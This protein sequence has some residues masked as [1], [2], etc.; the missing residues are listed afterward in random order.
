[1]E[2]A[3][4]LITDY[5]LSGLAHAVRRRLNARP[6]VQSRR[7]A[8]LVRRSMAESVLAAQRNYQF[9]KDILI[10]ILMPVYNTDIDMLGCV[11]ESVIAQTYGR[12]ELCICDA[13]DEAHSAVADRCEKYAVADS[14]IKYRRLTANGGIAANTNECA[15]AASGEYFALL[16]H[17]DILH[18][19][20]LYKVAREIEQSGADFIYT[21]ELTFAGSIDNVLLTN[22]KPDYSPDTLCGNNYICHFTAFARELY[23][24]VCGF[25]SEYNGSQDHDIFLRMTRAANK[26]AHIPEILYFWRAH[27][28]SVVE[29]VS[30]K[31]YAVDAGK[32]AV[33]DN[34]ADWGYQAEVL[35]TD[36]YPTVYRIKY[37]ISNMP[38]VSVII[39]TG[40]NAPAKECKASLAVTGYGNYEVI[41][42]AADSASIN[43]CVRSVAKGDYIL[44]LDGRAKPGKADWMEELLRYAMRQEVGAVGTGL[45]NKNGT[46]DCYYMITGI[47]KDGIVLPTGRGLSEGDNGYLGRMGFV[48]NVNVPCPACLMVSRDKYIAAGGLDEKLSVNYN[49]IDLCLKLRQSGYNNVYTPF[50]ALRR[51]ADG[52]AKKSD[53]S[54]GAYGARAGK[55]EARYLAAKWGDALRDPY[56]NANFRKDGTYLL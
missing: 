22:L 14:R 4:S 42:T 7:A 28:G 44:L 8:G 2:S 50:A 37:N 31:S 25:R 52:S 10:S 39:A 47:G 30:A 51:I 17:D 16:D 40:E 36:V 27:E 21:D 43:E 12:W 34:L 53:K 1:M 20:A 56:Y 29:D 49:R 18:P 32:K 55:D 11:I 19:A 5:G 3:L 38:L 48:Q 41:E 46:V 26:V 23:D 13:S 33:R 24:S 54:D 9:K 6:Q 15:D 45:L 35:S